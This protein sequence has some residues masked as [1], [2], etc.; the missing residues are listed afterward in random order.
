MT[1]RKLWKGTESKQLNDELLLIC[2]DAFQV[3]SEEET[4]G[5]LVSDQGEGVCLKAQEL[6]MGLNVTDCPKMQL[7]VTAGSVLRYTCQKTQRP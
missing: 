6:H 4:A 2:P 1:C 7:D 5:F 3:M